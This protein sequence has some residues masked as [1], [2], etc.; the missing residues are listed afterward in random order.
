MKKIIE[1]SAA[2]ARYFIFSD[3]GPVLLYEGL[4]KPDVML[5]VK[6]KDTIEMVSALV[7]VLSTLKIH[8]FYLKLKNGIVKLAEEKDI[9]K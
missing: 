7:F 9:R 5:S 3:V 8:S 4:T 1:F 2:A 6:I